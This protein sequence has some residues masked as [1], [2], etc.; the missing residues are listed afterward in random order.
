MFDAGTED[1]SSPVDVSDPPLTQVSPD[2]V[3]DTHHV[4]DE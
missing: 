2:A 3:E 4:D 1:E